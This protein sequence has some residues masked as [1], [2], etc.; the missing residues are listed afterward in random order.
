MTGGMAAAAH[1]PLS[2]RAAILASAERRIRDHG[3]GA[4]RLTDIT[5]DAGL[6]TGAF[7][8]QFT[9]KDALY[10]A[11]FADLAHAL[12]EALAGARDLA[13]AI[14]AWLEVSRAFPGTVRAQ[15]E[16]IRPGTPFLAAWERARDRW[17]GA[18]LGVLPGRSPHHRIVAAL[19]AD[20]L[21]YYAFAD[22]VGWFEPRPVAEVAAVVA[23]VVGEGIYPPW[24]GGTGSGAIAFVPLSYQTSMYWE[25]APGKIVPTSARG[26]RTMERVRAAALEVFAEVGVREATMLDI[27]RA[28]DVASGTTYRYF[29]DK[30]DLL[31]SL[32]AGAERALV[33]ASF[34]ALDDNRL[35]AGPTYRSFLDLHRREA[36]VFRAWWELMEPGSP[37]EAAWVRMHSTLMAQ[38]VRVLEH[39]RRRGIVTDDL[40]F[41]LVARVYSGLH[42]RSAYTRVVLGRELGCT[43]DEVADVVDRMLNGGVSSMGTVGENRRSRSV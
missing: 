4:A 22:E 36:G 28:A 17:E 33:Q 27:A 6:T 38:F 37:Y 32:L 10:E 41:D 40:D 35:A 21:E 11:M 24:P 8:R 3:F 26:L 34:H 23:R 29:D 19:V 20:T 7:Y 12:D 31:R 9:S 39:G 43:D 14:A 1:E 16:V 42:E 30:E 15:I 13:G 2:T 18:L 5:A 25:P